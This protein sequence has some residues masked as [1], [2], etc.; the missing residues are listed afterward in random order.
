MSSIAAPVAPSAPS[1]VSAGRRDA[2]PSLSVTA[3]FYQELAEWKSMSGGFET[4]ISC[5]LLAQYR[6]K[7]LVLNDGV[8]FCV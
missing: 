2:L 7:V 3:D 6:R 8:V 1:T 5:E 4:L